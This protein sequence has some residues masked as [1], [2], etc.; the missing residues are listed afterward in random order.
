MN[1]LIRFFPAAIICFVMAAVALSQ[2][3]QTDK[4]ADAQDQSVQLQSQLLEI[5]AVVTDKQG[6]I[7]KNLKKED[8]EL[9]ENKNP[10][11]I[12]FFS[13]E[14]LADK[15]RIPSNPGVITSGPGGKSIVSTETPARTAVLYID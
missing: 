3:S 12:S 9:L 10:Q 8:F 15:T 6:H 7:I 1:R 4:K 14:D 5:H 11:E 2:S 13:M